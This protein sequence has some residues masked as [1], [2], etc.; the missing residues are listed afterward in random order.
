MK[1]VIQM[2]FPNDTINNDFDV[3]EENEGNIIATHKSGV[4]DIFFIWKGPDRCEFKELKKDNEEKGLI[5][6][7]KQHGGY[8]IQFRASQSLTDGGKERN[9]IATGF[10]SKRDLE[11][12]L[13][14]L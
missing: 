4:S 7:M 11:Y 14:Q 13:S 2:N 6:A 1:S 10:L 3:I 12:L 9:L 5:R 8:K